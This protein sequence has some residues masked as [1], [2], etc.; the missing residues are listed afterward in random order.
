MTGG[1]LPTKVWRDLMVYAHLSKEPAYLPGTDQFAGRS[2]ERRRPSGN[3]IWD[4]L[5][6]DTGAVGR[7]DTTLGNPSTDSRDSGAPRKKSWLEE[8]FSP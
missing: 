6:S 3:S 4:N 7:N 1:S 5:F 8:L 2:R